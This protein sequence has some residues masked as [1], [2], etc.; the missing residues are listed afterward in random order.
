MKCGAEAQAIRE[1]VKLTI[2]CIACGYQQVKVFTS[3][4]G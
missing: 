2:K 4:G 3:K 1:K